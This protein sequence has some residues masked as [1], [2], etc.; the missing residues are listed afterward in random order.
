MLGQTMSLPISQRSRAQEHFRELHNRGRRALI[1]QKALGRHQGLLGLMATVGE[2][3]ILTSHALGLK[4]VPIRQIQGSEGRPLDFDRRFRPL[5]PQSKERWISI[6][7][8][9][10]QDVPLP[11]VDLVKVGDHYFV[12]DGHHRISVAWTYG[13]IDIDAQVTVWEVAAQPMVVAQRPAGRLISALRLGGSWVSQLVTAL[14][15]QHPLHHWPALRP[16]V[17]SV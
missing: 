9:R 3:R 2:R 4:T 6:A 14:V 17:E 5:R 13:Q 16:P 11:P 8:A 10:E 7:V 1:W 15:R 12:R